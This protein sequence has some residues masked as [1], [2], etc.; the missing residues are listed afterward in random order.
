MS[1]QDF[2]F[3]DEETETTDAKA[4]KASDKTDKPSDKTDK[5]S[6]K[7]S[8]K[9]VSGKSGSKPAPT[10]SAKSS[11][12]AAAKIAAS[13]KTAQAPPSFFDQ[14]VTVAIASLLAIAALLVGVIIG[15]FMFNGAGQTTA[16]AP[17]S[18]TT[19]S[20]TGTGTG[21]PPLTQDQLNSGQLPQGHPKLPSTTTTPA[22]K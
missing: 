6:D 11:S 16:T 7:P 14:T 21:A 9:A 15:Y 13:K 19:P 22:A 10:P 8:D 5:P 17:G 18:F 3:E 1:D 2:F 4:A 20:T 12:A